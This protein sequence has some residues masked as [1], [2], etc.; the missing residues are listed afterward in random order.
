MQIIIKQNAAEQDRER[1]MEW[2]RMAKN[3]HITQN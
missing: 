1:E 2:E 3:I